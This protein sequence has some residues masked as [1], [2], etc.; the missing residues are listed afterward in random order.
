MDLELAAWY[1]WGDRLA[2]VPL[3]F[4]Q[5]L[6]NVGQQSGG[7]FDAETAAVQHQVVVGKDVFEIGRAS[8]RK[9]V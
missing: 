5:R 2:P 4:K 7:A 8:C 6:G 9:R 3:R 1:K